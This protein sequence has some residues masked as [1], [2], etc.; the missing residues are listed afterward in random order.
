MR[1]KIERD[2]NIANTR[3]KRTKTP[4]VQ[5]K[6]LTEFASNQALLHLNDCRVKPFN[7]PNCKFDSMD[8]SKLNKCECFLDST[9]NRFFNQH[10]DAPVE[11][12]RCNLKVQVGGYNDR[13][14]IGMCFLN[15]L[16]I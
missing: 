7:V 6:Y 3:R 5:M 9:G 13:D 2:T 16:L 4:S 12:I 8:T 10:I 1:G 14:K 15:H 11:Q